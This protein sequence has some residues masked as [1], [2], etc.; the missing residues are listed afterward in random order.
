MIIIVIGNTIDRKFNDY[1][2]D[3]QE[4]NDKTGA[5]TYIRILGQFE[6]GLFQY[7]LIPTNSLLKNS[8]FEGWITTI[9]EANLVGTPLL[10]SDL[11]VHR[12]Q[13]PSAHFFSIDD[14]GLLADAIE[15][16]RP[17][18]LEEIRESVSN[19][20]EVN[21]SRARSFAE[22]FKNVIFSVHSSM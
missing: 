14:A 8:R 16:S 22:D 2:G 1:R 6:C 5:R 10:L 17:R 13:A 18:M 20:G 3:M 19:A 11:A 15:A 4:L 12:E 21:I 9:E 7:M